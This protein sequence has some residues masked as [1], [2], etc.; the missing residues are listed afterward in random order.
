MPG[1]TTFLPFP[2]DVPTHPL[3]VV[4]YEQIRAGKEEEIDTLWEAATKLGFWYLKNHG[5]DELVEDM[6]AMGAETMALP[7]EEKMKYE[8]GDG[9]LS[10]GYKKVGANATDET[11]A[12]DTVEFINIAK[13]DALAWPQIAHRTYPSTVNARMDST[14]KPFVRKSIE[15]NNTLLGVLND[16]LG[17]QRGRSAVHQVASDA[18]RV[19]RV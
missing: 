14:I 19:T 9:G 11:G 8:Q 2:E 6:F 16:R 15:I 13:D 7:M 10:C 18:R 1:I 12:L 17:V 3:L 4:D 5:A